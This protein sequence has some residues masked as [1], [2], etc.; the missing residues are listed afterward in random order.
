MTV[1]CLGG[2][3]F[4]SFKTSPSCS[5]I[6]CIPDACIL[7]SESRHTNIINILYII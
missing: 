5:S 4:A 3:D 6:L 1:L 2:R 7:F